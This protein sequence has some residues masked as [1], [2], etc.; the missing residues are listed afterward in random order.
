MLAIY[1][2]QKLPVIVCLWQTIQTLELLAV[3]RK[4]REIPSQDLTGVE[5][6]EDTQDKWKYIF[7]KKKIING[8]S[9]GDM[10]ATA[11]RGEA[12]EE[13]ALGK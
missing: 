3:G 7:R 6:H 5:G 4:A 10:P 13:A 2:D 9:H 12:L 1:V 8:F 11:I